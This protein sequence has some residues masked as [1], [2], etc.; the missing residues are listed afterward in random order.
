MKINEEL[1][2]VFSENMSA[3]IKAGL[4]VLDS[5]KICEKIDE[6]KER[7][8]F[9]SEL[10][11]KVSDGFLL[12]DSLKELIYYKAEK[13]KI[14]KTNS[15]YL[16]LIHLGEVS[17]KI[18]IVFERL[19]EYLKKKKEIK[20]KIVTAM[21]YP[22]LVFIT[23]IAVIFIIVVFVFPKMN[24]VFEILSENSPDFLRTVNS[25]KSSAFFWLLIA[26]VLG[27]VLIEVNFLAVRY[28]SVKQVF[29]RLLFKLPAVKRYFVMKNT[30]DF[31]FAMK[32]LTGAG[33]SFSDSLEEAE[34]A[35]S[36]E[37]YKNEIRQFKNNVQQGRS[38]YESSKEIK[39]FP[40]YFKLWFGIGQMTG[41]VNEVFFQ[42]YEY[43][44]K[45]LSDF[46]LRLTSNIENLFILVT[47]IVIFLLVIN[48]VLP[49]FNML[50]KV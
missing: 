12:S 1:L 29:D 43:C 17:G 24:T 16:S 5:L 20:D 31:V 4:S 35:V 30:F 9:Y 48:F 39:L 27:T 37:A 41:N 28:K 49:V 34:N 18:E 23:A 3:L 8:Q 15:L 25:F 22:I 11:N 2:L 26:V 32:I 44:N 40:E 50:G 46:I 6:S 13:K 7:K 45:K 19:R 14:I 42:V 36:N 21:I 33:M 10:I 47:G 38:L